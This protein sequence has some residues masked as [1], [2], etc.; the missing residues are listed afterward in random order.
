MDAHT[1]AG[2]FRQEHR[3]YQ[4]VTQ[5]YTTTCTEFNCSDRLALN[6]TE[7]FT[8]ALTDKNKFIRDKNEEQAITIVADIDRNKQV[9]VY[10]VI[11]ALIIQKCMF[12]YQSMLW[13]DMLL[14]IQFYL[15]RF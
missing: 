15:G 2:K 9:K 3:D 6:I 14:I 1:H 13:N 12:S 5:I 4:P 8:I 7:Q 11:F 10:H